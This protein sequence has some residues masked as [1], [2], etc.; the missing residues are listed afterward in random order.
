MKN[1]LLSLMDINF[2][3]FKIYRFH[4]NELYIYIFIAL[5]IR[6]RIIAEMNRII[7]MIKLLHWSG[8]CWAHPHKTHVKS[9]LYEVDKLFLQKTQTT[10]QIPSDLAIDDWFWQTVIR[11]GIPEDHKI[12][13]IRLEV[14]IQGF[15]R[16]NN[17]IL[18][19]IMSKNEILFWGLNPNE[20]IVEYL[21]SGL[22]FLGTSHANSEQI[23]AFIRVHLNFKFQSKIESS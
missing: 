10:Q 4:W 2:W 9:I 15:G 19:Y 21:K 20:T 12:H 17:S 1:I 18:I 6:H 14:N 16:Q 3:N 8:R 23:W 5:N 22:N 11:D 13:C 7:F